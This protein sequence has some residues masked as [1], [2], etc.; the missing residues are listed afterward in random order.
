[1]KEDPYQFNNL[2]TR[3]EYGDTLGRTRKLLDRWKD[4]TGDSIPA[5]PTPSRQPLHENVRQGPIRGEFPGA[6]RGATEIN[7]PG[8][9][10]IDDLSG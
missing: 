3:S 5:N 1:V 4:E 2:A 8:P 6:S 10:R 7:R 9:V